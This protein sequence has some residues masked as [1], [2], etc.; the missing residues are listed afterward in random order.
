MDQQAMQKAS[1]PDLPEP[2]GPISKVIF[3]GKM[4]PETL[5]K[6]STL[7]RGRGDQNINKLRN[8]VYTVE[9]SRSASTLV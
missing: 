8:Q 1:I 4:R 9:I 2:G 6:M 7:F 5:A 3:R